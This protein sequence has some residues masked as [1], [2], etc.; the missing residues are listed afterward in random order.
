MQAGAYQVAQQQVY[1]VS[2]QAAVLAHSAHRNHLIQGLRGRIQSLASTE[3]L[4][5]FSLKEMFSEV[6]KRRSPDDVEDYLL[7][8]TSKTTPPLEMVETGWPK[9]WLFFR[10]LAALVMAARAY[11]FDRLISAL[12]ALANFSELV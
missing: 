7:V 9:P 10:V 12:D 1:Y 6:F 5:G 3:D 11:G 8:G 2:H 4:E